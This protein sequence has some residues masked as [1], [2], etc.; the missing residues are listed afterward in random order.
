M[1]LCKKYRIQNGNTGYS[2]IIFQILREKSE[3]VIPK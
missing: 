1:L 3:E 2:Q